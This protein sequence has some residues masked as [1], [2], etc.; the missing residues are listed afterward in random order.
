MAVLEIL[1]A[2]ARWDTSGLSKSISMNDRGTLTTG[3]FNPDLGI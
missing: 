2:Y 1:P 3:L